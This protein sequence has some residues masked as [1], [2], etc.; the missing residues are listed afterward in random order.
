MCVSQ[1]HRIRKSSSKRS[2]SFDSFVPS[3][4]TKKKKDPVLVESGSYGSCATSFL[5]EHT[6]LRLPVF[7]T[8][9][10]VGGSLI[11]SR[12]LGFYTPCFLSTL[13]SYQL[14]SWRN[15]QTLGLLTACHVVYLKHDLSVSLN[16]RC[17]DT[18]T[19]FERN[20]GK[21][22]ITCFS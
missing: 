14:E 9:L 10:F 12:Y 7:K 5:N 6:L 13:I 18:D 11:S 20:H 2:L 3:K 17:T 4:V 15:L 19:A 22:L 8:D 16:Y 1:S 21:R